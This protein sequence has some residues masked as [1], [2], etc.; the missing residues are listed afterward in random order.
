MLGEIGALDPP[1]LPNGAKVHQGFI[2]YFAGLEQA[3]IKGWN[4]IDA[5]A[6]DPATIGDSVTQGVKMMQD[7]STSDMGMG[8]LIGPEYKDAMT[9]IDSCAPLLNG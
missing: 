4:L 2:T 8:N 6:A 1:N 9:Q 5:A 3:I 7:A